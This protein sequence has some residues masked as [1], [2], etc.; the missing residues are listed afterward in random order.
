[1]LVVGVAPFGRSGFF[2]SIAGAAKEFF[3]EFSIHSELF[4][5]KYPRLSHAMCKG[6]RDP[7]YGSNKHKQKV[8]NW[9]R[10]CPLFTS[11]LDNTKEGRWFQIVDRSLASLPHWPCLDLAGCYMGTVSGWDTKYVQSDVLECDAP[12]PGTA[13]STAA[14]SSS[15]SGGTPG[16][17]AAPAA[18]VEEDEDLEDVMRDY[19]PGSASK[20]DTAPSSSGNKSKTMSG[21]SI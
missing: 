20:P 19:M 12:P 17:G 11:R 5:L 4:E 10:S 14:S 2:G 3:E 7:D 18:V 13:S 9:A 6:A 15:A 8:F 1:V 21:Q 16:G